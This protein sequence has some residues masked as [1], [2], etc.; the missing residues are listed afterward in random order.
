MKAALLL[1][2]LMGILGLTKA[3]AQQTL[4]PDPNFEQALI[5]LGHDDVLDGQVRTANISGVNRL[6]VNGKNITSLT[7]IQD[8]SAP[9]SYTLTLSEGFTK[10]YTAKVTGPSFITTWDITDLHS[11]KLN[12]SF[13]YNFQ[14]IWTDDTGNTITSGTH[15]DADGNDFL[16]EFDEPG[17]Y[18]LEINGAFPHFEAN[19]ITQL[20]DVLKWVDIQWKTMFESFKNWDQ[21]VF[22]AIDAPDLS[23]ATSLRNMFQNATV[24]ND[25]LNHWDVSTIVDFSRMFQSAEAFNGNI[26][27]WAVDTG[28]NFQAM[29]MFASAFNRDISAWATGEATK[30]RDM[31]RF[32]TSFN[33]QLNS[34]NVSNV[35]NMQ[36]MFSNAILFNADISSWDVGAVDT[37]A[38]MFQ[39]AEVFNQNISNWNTESATILNS[40]F[41]QAPDF[42]KDLSLWD[43][44]NVTDM[45]NIFDSSGLSSQNYDSI[46]IGWANLPTLQNN[47]VLGAQ[48]TTFCEAEDARSLL[49]DSFNWTVT[50]AGKFCLEELPDILS[51]ELP[52]QTE[53]A[54]IDAENH[55]VEIEVEE[56]TDVSILIPVLTLSTGATS[57]PSNGEVI[58][59][60]NDVVYNLIAQDG[61]TTQD[62]IVSV[63]VE[64]ILNIEDNELVFN[65]YPNPVN[66]ILNINTQKE[67]R[68]TITDF[69][70]K[71]MGVDQIGSKIQLDLSHF[72]SGMYFLILE[73]GQNVS[74]KKI[75]KN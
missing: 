53:A 42:N 72:S 38:F 35:T 4:I 71:K 12:P 49:M 36:G 62:W 50:D 47:V 34:W 69:N 60:T 27:N 41:V 3:S 67:V 14:Y 23:Q 6:N 58:D 32:A 43:V 19:D 55:T 54:I 25:D 15:T 44:S 1:L 20:L 5:D 46:L 37:F 11:L 52:Q 75:V 70:G 31:F 16:T 40:M 74:V 65:I 30:M 59:F 28:R 29:F 68:V 22:S 73:D 10:E 56:G 61:V 17:R 57:L 66:D 33:Q 39:N 51:F 13:D 24:F 63:S 18:Q 9:V 26:Q 8:F 48:Q 21:V 45:A 64:E 7:G 2:S